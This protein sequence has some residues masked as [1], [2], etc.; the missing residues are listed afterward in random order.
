MFLLPFIVLGE[1]E[2]G[3]LLRTGQGVALTARDA[4]DRGPSLLLDWCIGA[5]PMGVAVGAVLGVASYAVAH[6][7]ARKAQAKAGGG[8]ELKP[9]P[10]ASA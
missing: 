3:S 9:P 2:M 8:P 5:V 1:V 6:R 10:A 7:R 4:L